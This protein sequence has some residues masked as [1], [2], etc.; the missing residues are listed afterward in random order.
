[1]NNPNQEYE[2]YLVY[3]HGVCQEYNKSHQEEYDSLHD[4]ISA[5]I[6]RDVQ[7]WHNAKRCYVEW[8]WDCENEGEQAQSH[9]LLAKAQ[10]V[11]AARIFPKIEE[12]SD[13][14]L[15][16]ARLFLPGARELMLKGF[17]DMFYY[18]SEDGQ[19]SVRLE[20]LS[21]IL[22]ENDIQ[23]R[24]AEEQ[25]FSI[26]LLGHS[27]GSVIAFDLLLYLFSKDEEET[28]SIEPISE[29]GGNVSKTKL[30]KKSFIDF[31]APSVQNTLKKQSLAITVN[32]PESNPEKLQEN[33][34]KFRT[35][36]QEGKI[37]AL[38]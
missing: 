20:V 25:P 9:H 23:N 5:C 34:E 30:R 35:M 28:Q 1:M 36:A 15:N 12:A 29:G 24:L 26:T 7:E 8:G 4:G 6:S 17:S 13:L 33:L 32:S 21:T 11:L 22:G 31:K 38:T 2:E 37:R 14:N 3:I 27:A 19:N 18:A 10:E 16:P